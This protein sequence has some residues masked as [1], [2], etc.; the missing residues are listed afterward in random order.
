MNNFPSPIAAPNWNDPDT[1]PANPTPFD[2]EFDGASL[3]SKWRP[4]NT[5]LQ[6]VY[7]DHGFLVMDAQNQTDR[8]HGIQQEVGA[9][10]WR[11]RAKLETAIQQP[12]YLAYGMAVR[13][14][15]NGYLDAQMIMHHLGYNSIRLLYRGFFSSY[16][17]LASEP[18][19]SSSGYTHF[20]H[21]W[22]IESDGSNV[23]WRMSTDGFNFSLIDTRAYS[24][25]LGGAPDEICLVQ[26]PHGGTIQTVCDWFR[27]MA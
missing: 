17:V 9:G 3:D 19:Y 25:W 2:D 22:E 5:G 1:P 27:R 11:F 8:L 16:T 23:I 6:R 18:W 13:R 7:V 15:T 21:Y 4:F 26:H 24:A 10:T 20:A 12:D 14:S